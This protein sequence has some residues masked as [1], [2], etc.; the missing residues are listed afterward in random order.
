[1]EVCCGRYTE[2]QEKGTVLKRVALPCLDLYLGS[3]NADVGTE[4]KLR[5]DSRENAGR[6]NAG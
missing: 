3:P 1:M 5:G 6:G 2:C 4:S